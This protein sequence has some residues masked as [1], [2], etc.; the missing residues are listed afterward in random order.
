[1]SHTISTEA[2]ELVL[3]A[4]NTYDLYQYALRIAEKVRDGKYY[5]ENNRSR[6]TVGIAC[7]RF[8]NAVI[9][10]YKQ[11]FGDFPVTPQ[12]RNELTEYFENDV[13]EWEF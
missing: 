6:S 8:A 2:R 3:Y 4:E 9:R 13:K 10:S 5:P 1:M 7:R 11:E 12:L